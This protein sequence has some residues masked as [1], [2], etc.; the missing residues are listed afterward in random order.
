MNWEPSARQR[1]GN[2]RN[3]TDS[4]HYPQE[5]GARFAEGGGRFT[6]NAP[7]DAAPA[8]FHLEALR[9]FGGSCGGSGRE[10]VCGL[11]HS[12]LLRP[13]HPSTERDKAK[14]N[15]NM[16]DQADDWMLPLFELLVGALFVGIFWG[17]AITATIEHFR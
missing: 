8:L 5:R 15:T 17:A 9:R 1:G 12:W 4:R 14:E 10:A 6:R 13:L 3:C 7:H 16:T 11:R 2:A